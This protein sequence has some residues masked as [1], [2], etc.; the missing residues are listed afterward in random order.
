MDPTAFLGL[1]RSSK[2]A[3]SWKP[4]VF[5]VLP[6]RKNLDT[7]FNKASWWILWVEDPSNFH[8]R[9]FILVFSLKTKKNLHKIMKKTK[10]K[11][12]NLLKS[13][14]YRKMLYIFRKCI[15]KNLV[16]ISIFVFQFPWVADYLKCTNETTKPIDMIQ[17]N[18]ESVLRLKILGNRIDV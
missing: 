10:G 8:N 1:N 11:K 2:C 14:L 13:V 3:L 15:R 16:C 4:N 17:R 18:V 7:K 5:I 9:F 12:K 6:F